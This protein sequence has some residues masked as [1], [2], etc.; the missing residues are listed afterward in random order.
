MPTLPANYTRQALAA[1]VS[2]KWLWDDDWTTVGWLLA[3]YVEFSAGPDLDQ[4]QLTWLYGNILYP[5]AAEYTVVDPLDLKGAFIQVYFIPIVVGSSVGGAGLGAPTGWVG[6]CIEVKDSPDGDL[7]DVSGTPP[8]GIQQLICW[9]LGHDLDQVPIISTVLTDDLT[10]SGSDP[11]LVMIRRAVGFNMGKG[12]IERDKGQVVVGNRSQYS[13][14]QECFAFRTQINGAA[15]WGLFD[16]AQYL[17]TYYT[18]ADDDPPGGTPWVPWVVYNPHVGPLTGLTWKEATDNRSTRDIINSLFSRKR[19]LGYWIDP[20]G[21]D[22]DSP[23]ATISVFSLTPTAISLGGGISLGAN[24]NTF[25]LDFTSDPWLG[26]LEIRQTSQTLYDQVIARGARKG[27]VATFSGKDV[28][29]DADWSPSQE[30][31]YDNGASTQAGYGALDDFDKQQRNDAV[32]QQHALER[33]YCWWRLSELSGLYGDLYAGHGEATSSYTYVFPTFAQDTGLPV[34]VDTTGDDYWLEGLRFEHYLPFYIDTD[35]SGD[36]IKFGTT[37]NNLPSG[38][39]DDFMQPIVALKLTRDDGSTF[40][41]HADKLAAEQQAAQNV[42]PWCNFSVSVSMQ[43]QAPGLKLKV[44]APGRAQQHL[45]CKAEFTPCDA[46]DK[47]DNAAVLDWNDNLLITVYIKADSYAECRVPPDAS[48]TSISITRLV[49]DVP[50]AYMD[51]VCPNTVVALNNGALVRS[52]GG[53]VRNDFARL[54]RIALL[55]SGWYAIPRQT[56]TIQYNRIALIGFIGDLITSVNGQ[57]VNTVVTK[58]RYDFVN[59]TTTVQTSHGELDW[60]AW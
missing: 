36:G 51:W 4:A 48:L 60:N 45:L 33:V 37:I 54:Q 11:T 49:I 55:A 8:S 46:A 15:Q 21:T 28:T 3:D 52:S 25:S 39:V 50:D 7:A 2:Y 9:G 10:A 40:Y 6:R 38:S 53:L 13:T 22:P 24:P 23:T 42:D 17:A 20:V 56:V 31:L 30:M 26:N 16:A 59:Q 47:D 58:S 35:Y 29:L 1:A 27:S 44:H 43:D 41:A 5:G 34:N 57:T 12:A 18:L 14:P 32:R 19:A